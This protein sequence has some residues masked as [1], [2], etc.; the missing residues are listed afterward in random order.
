[1]NDVLAKARVVILEEKK[2]RA[3]EC[4]EEIRAVLEEYSCIYTVIPAFVEDSP[5][6]FVVVGELKIIPLDE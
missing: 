5:G 4:F 1:M 6:K 2:Q 3:I